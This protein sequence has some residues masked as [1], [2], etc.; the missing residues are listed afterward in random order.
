MKTPPLTG[1]ID[2]RILLNFRADPAV[3]GRLLPG[4]FRAQLVQ[5]QAMV[6]ICL[7][8]LKKVRPKGFPAVF[9]LASENGAHRIAV[10]WDADGQPRKGVYIP[11]RDTSSRLNFLVGNQLLGLHYRSPFRVQEQNGR[12]AIAFQSTDGTRLAVEARETAEW[13]KTSLFSTLEQA[14]GFFRQGAAGYSPSPGGQGFDGVELSTSQ[15]QVSPL[16]VQQVSS[17]FFADETLF[18]AGSV[19]FDNALLMRNVPHEWQRLTSLRG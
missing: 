5:G 18:P 6:G 10:E 4:P 15:W 2:R 14:S 16:S 7:I 8:R 13:P 9:G 19:V 11:R 1:L 17:S 12:Y 3:V